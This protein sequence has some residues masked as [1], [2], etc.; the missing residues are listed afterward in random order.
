M[1]SRT[2]ECPRE[3]TTDT[4]LRRSPGWES[5][6]IVGIVAYDCR[7]WLSGVLERCAHRQKATFVKDMAATLGSDQNGRGT[8]EW[9]MG[10]V[11]GGRLQ[12]ANR[13]GCFDTCRETLTTS[14]GMLHRWRTQRAEE[15]TT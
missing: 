10:V 13:G 11:R 6:T 9:S 3:R 12:R 7:G 5:G 15:T 2:R 1:E 8:E 4:E 14:R